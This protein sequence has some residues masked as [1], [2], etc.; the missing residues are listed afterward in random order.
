LHCI[1]ILF[2]QLHKQFHT[3]ATATVKCEVRI[4]YPFTFPIS[5][6]TRQVASCVLNV[7]PRK[8][9]DCGCPLRQWR[10]LGGGGVQR[11]SQS[12]WWT[13]RPLQDCCWWPDV[14][15]VVPF[16]W[17]ALFATRAVDVL[18]QAASLLPSP[19]RRKMWT[20]VSMLINLTISVHF[21]TKYLDYN[22]ESVP[23]SNTVICNARI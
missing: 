14:A 17:L 18:A 23:F 12:T 3:H 22:F 4:T 8:G 7:V 19:N 10:G 1:L 13:L 21:Y 2:F 6:P 11:P 5:W 16:M 15:V 9:G 20:Q